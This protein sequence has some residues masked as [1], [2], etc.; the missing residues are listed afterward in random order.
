MMDKEGIQK[1][2]L[3]YPTSDAHIKIGSWSAL[4]KIY[5]AEIARIVKEHPGRFVGAA[6]LP[7][8]EKE[9]ML[10]EFK[11]AMDLG[12]KVLSLASSYFSHYLD[13]EGFH[14]IYEEAQKKNVPIFVHS[15]I[16]NPIG[17]ERVQ[18][19]LLTPV[20]QYVFDVTIC[21]GKLMMSGVFDK[22][23]KLNFIFA[24]FA[25]VL[26]FLKDRFDTVYTMLRQRQIVKDLGKAPSEIFKNI[27]VDTSGVTTKS[28]INLALEMFGPERVLWGSDYPA[29]RD[30]KST[31]D[32]IKQLDVKEVEKELILSGNSDRILQAGG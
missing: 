22:F 30:V 15:Q 23:P 19:P 32:A 27:Y 18:D 3:L 14:C 31:I 20:I 26:P 6:I 16:I 12:L 21:V 29:K 1:S 7:Y 28:L 5:N 25:G 9:D 11:Q 13:D 4:C 8:G 10:P 17:S 2:V 24:H